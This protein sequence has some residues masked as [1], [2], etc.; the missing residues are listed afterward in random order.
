MRVLGGAN[1]SESQ[2]AFLPPPCPRFDLVV[3]D[4]LAPVEMLRTV[5]PLFLEVAPLERGVP[6]A[7]ELP[8]DRVLELEVFLPLELFCAVALLE[9][10]E[11]LTLVLRF[12]L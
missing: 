10:R 6:R 1:R 3:A 11:L 5:P 2:A 9:V 8:G 4:F 12:A 7:L